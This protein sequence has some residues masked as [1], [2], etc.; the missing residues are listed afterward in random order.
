MQYPDQFKDNQRF[1]KGAILL[2]SLL[3]IFI[4]ASGSNA[5]LT[6]P[7]HPIALILGILLPAYLF[8]LFALVRRHSLFAELLLLLQKGWQKVEKPLRKSLSNSSEK[9]NEPDPKQLLYL[10]KVIMHGAWIL[11]FATLLVTLFFQFTL[12]QYSFNLFSTL[13]PDRS[14]FYFLI[15]Q[16]L[17]FLPDLIAGELISPAIVEHSLNLPPTAIEN[18]AWARWILIMIALYGLIP[19]II[20]FLLAQRSYKKYLKDQQKNEHRSLLSGEG[21]VIDA[22]KARPQSLRPPK[23]IRYGEGE[24]RI[25]LDYVGEVPHSKES[26]KIVEIINSRADFQQLLSQLQSSPLAYLIIYIDTQLTP[27]RSL[28]RRIYTLMNL[29]LSTEI[30]LVTHQNPSR[31]EEWQHKL[32]PNLYKDERILLYPAPQKVKNRGDQPPRS[33]SDPLS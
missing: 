28:L 27:D 12:K 21:K 18:A 19:R 17:N 7:I 22:A 10:S 31:E 5:L 2:F 24:K 14:D 20:L 30:I 8:L 33:N 6:S 32:T 15:I 29:A 9:I 1:S 3:I 4:T 11:I 26:D 23:S 16:L 25:A 13:F